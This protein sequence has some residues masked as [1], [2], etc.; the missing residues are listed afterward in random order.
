[1][2]DLYYLFERYRHLLVITISRNICY[3]AS[4]VLVSISSWLFQKLYIFI[5][6]RYFFFAILMHQRNFQTSYVRIKKKAIFCSNKR[7]INFL[8]RVHFYNRVHLMLFNVTQVMYDLPFITQ[9][10]AKRRYSATHFI[11]NGSAKLAV[12]RRSAD[13]SFYS[14]GV[15]RSSTWEAVMGGNISK[16]LVSGS[17]GRGFIV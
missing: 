16:Q 6:I 15:H 17:F 2:H 4:E 8:R 3:L 13:R 14:R 1:M 5:K 7:A 10:S 11:P 12:V 9:N